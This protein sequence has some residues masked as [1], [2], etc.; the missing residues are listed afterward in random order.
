MVLLDQNK[1]KDF[2]TSRGYNYHYYYAA[3]ADDK[4]TL[5]CLHGFPTNS[6][7]WSGVVAYFTLRGYGAIVPDLLGERFYALRSQTH[8][9]DICMQGM[10]ALTSLVTPKSIV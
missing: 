1:Y 5:L 3:P 6:L 9:D 4:P 10:L 8:F 7:D 2:R